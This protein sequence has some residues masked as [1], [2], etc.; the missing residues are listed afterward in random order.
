MATSRLLK[1]DLRQ[2]NLTMRFIVYPSVM[3]KPFRNFYSVS[4]YKDY[5]IKVTYRL[6]LQKYNCYLSLIF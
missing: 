6:I 4:T 5:K 3:L 1:A 2:I